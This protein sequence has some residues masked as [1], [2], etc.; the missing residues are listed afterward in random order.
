MTPSLLARDPG[1]L[2]GWALRAYDQRFE[3]GG[4]HLPHAVIAQECAP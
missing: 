1:T 4:R 3:N 2:M